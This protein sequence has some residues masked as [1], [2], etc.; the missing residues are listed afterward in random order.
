MKESYFAQ[1]LSEDSIYAPYSFKLILTNPST[2]VGG[3]RTNQTKS[4]TLG[5]VRRAGWKTCSISIPSPLTLS[6]IRLPVVDRRSTSVGPAAVGIGSL[7][8]NR[9]WRVRTRSAHS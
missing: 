8:A 7:I 2:I 9:L 6:W 4:V 3:R 1:I 5:I